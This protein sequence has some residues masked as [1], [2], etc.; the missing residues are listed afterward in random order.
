[1]PSL[2]AALFAALLFGLTTAVL[3]PLLSLSLSLLSP[4]PAAGRPGPA[5]HAAPWFCRAQV[6]TGGARR[7]AGPALPYQIARPHRELPWQG[8]GRRPATLLP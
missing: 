5:V 3:P 6:K 8:S 2:L 7:A 1:M 4:L